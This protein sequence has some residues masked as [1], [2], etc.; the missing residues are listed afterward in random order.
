VKITRIAQQHKRTDRYAVFVDDVYSFSLSEAA[1]LDSGITKN[2][3]VTEAQVGEFKKRADEDRVYAGVLRYIA[4][5]L[6]SAWGVSTYL[7]RKNIS[8]ALKH[9]ILN[10]LT[11]NHL[12]DDE[13]YA[14]AYIHDRQLTRPI[15][16]T[17][18]IFELR[19]KHIAQEIIDRVVSDESRDETDALK[20]L[21]AS[22]RQQSRYQDD[23]KLMQYLSR[24]GFHYSDI[25]T[26]M[27]SIE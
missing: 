5:R 6:R 20:Q 13:Q 22:K 26:A 24:Q 27:D 25:K 4:L 23:L 18:L 1:L 10:K 15:S 7:D 2:Q 17:K 9:E 11:I 14:Q 16:R 21:I 3:E 12:I 8:P 19:K